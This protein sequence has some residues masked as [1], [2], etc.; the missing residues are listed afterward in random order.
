MGS[1]MAEKA[2]DH[3]Y[4]AYQS[5]YAERNANTQ[6]KDNRAWEERMSNTAVQRRMKDMEEAGINPIL[7]GKYDATTPSG[8]ALATQ[9]YTG[10]GYNA[11]ATAATARK[12]DQ[13][14]AQSEQQIKNLSTQE[15]G[16]QI[17]NRIK[18]S[19]AAI[20]QNVEII[21]GE[22]NEILSRYRDSKPGIK[23]EAEKLGRALH[24]LQT[25]AVSSAADLADTV[26]TKANSLINNL[27][28]KWE[29]FKDSISSPQKLRK[30]LGLDN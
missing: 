25:N 19:N 27:K 9:P 1:S 18:Q 4:G 22:I 7:A 10:N 8:S 28:S 14:I 20:M 13:E 15:L 24:E 30:S 12:T 29:S 3:A 21:A 26:G 5:K 23:A 2:A 6:A 17:D 11:V 16:Y